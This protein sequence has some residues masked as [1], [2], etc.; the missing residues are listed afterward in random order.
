[1]EFRVIH[2]DSPSNSAA[3]NRRSVATVQLPCGPRSFLISHQ[4]LTA[5]DLFNPLSISNDICEVGEVFLEN[6][7]IQIFDMCD[8]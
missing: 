6:D 3:A 7:D 8:V 4:A 1:M 2:T 5:V